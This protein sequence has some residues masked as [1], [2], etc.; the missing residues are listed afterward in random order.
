MVTSQLNG[1]VVSSGLENINHP[2]YQLGY[3]NETAL[4]SIKNE[5]YLALSRDE[6]TAVVLID[7]LAEFDTT[8]HGTFK[9]CLS[10]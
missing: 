3:L 8:D 9:E 1:H 10:S 5:I 4:L 2:A 7:Q 6:A